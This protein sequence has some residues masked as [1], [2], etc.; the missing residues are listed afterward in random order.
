MPLSGSKR[1]HLRNAIVA[2]AF[3]AV[4]AAVTWVL[5]RGQ[6]A[7]DLSPGSFAATTTGASA[8]PEQP[9]SGNDATGASKPARKLQGA[10]TSAALPPPGIPLAQT[11][12]ELKAHAAAGD[13]EAASRLFTEAQHCHQARQT[14]RV[15]PHAANI[16][17]DEDTSKLNADELSQREKHLADL[18]QGLSKAKSETSCA[19]VL[20]MRNYSSH[21]LRLKR[22]SS[23]TRAPAIATSADSCCTR[24]GCSIIRNGWRNTRVAR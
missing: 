7:K 8:N 3:A 22:R 4:V 5:I 19:K 20:R 18:E 2:A 21:R 12:D 14:V 15:L 11:Y 6:S 10:V 1:H 23:A 17:L 13:M 16:F 24:A 9:A